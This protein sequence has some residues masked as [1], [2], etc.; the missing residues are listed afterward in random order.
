MQL[1]VEVKHYQSGQVYYSQ[2]GG[3]ITWTD[4]PNNPKVYYRW[5]AREEVLEN[6]SWIIK[7]TPQGEWIH[8]WEVVMKMPELFDS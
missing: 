5:M 7:E 2:H 6:G 4:P 8:R 3:Q 1:G